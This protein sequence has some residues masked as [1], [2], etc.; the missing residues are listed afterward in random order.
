MNFLADILLNKA[1]EI[2]ARKLSTPLER[3]KNTALYERRRVSFV[4]ALR[5]GGF[6]IIAEIKKASPSKGLLRAAFDPV[7]I[8]Q[9]YQ[10][11]GASALSVLTDETFFQGSL[12]DLLRVREA[13]ALPILRK[14][15]IIDSYQLHEAR[16]A[17]ADA[18]LL[19]VAALDPACL[20]DLNAEANEMGL[21]ALIEVHNVSEM[22]IARG[23]KPTIIGVNNRDLTTFK[24]SLETSLRL[25]QMLDREVLGVSESGIGK[26]EDLALLAGSGYH[27][28]LIGESFM[29]ESDPGN[30]L[31]R[32][33]EGFRRISA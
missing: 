7:Q 1:Q 14:D 28:A 6:G 18:V 16:A 29:R 25:A 20:R 24:T 26:P 9:S 27:A 31:R 10:L 3:L 8:A 13:S 4:Q 12:A 2:Q 22:E 23:L 33:L 11:G 30:A 15:F 19:I 17:G 5:S 32:L 21:D